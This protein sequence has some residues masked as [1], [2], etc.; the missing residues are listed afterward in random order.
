MYCG[1]K[2]DNTNRKS[3]ASWEHIRNDIN[4]ND[5]SN[6]ALCCISCNASKGNKTLNEWLNSDYCKKNGINENTVSEVVRNH[7]K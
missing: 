5:E 7:L 2:F 4:L 1:V 6:I 3:K